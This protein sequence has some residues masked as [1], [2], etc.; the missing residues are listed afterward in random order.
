MSSI[1]AGTTSGTALVSSGDTSGTLLLQTN[2]TTTAVTIGTNQVV[3]LAQPLPVASGGTGATSLSGV[4]VGNLTGGSN[5]T[6][7]YQTASGTTAMLAAGTSGQLLKSNGAS[8]PSW[9]TASASGLTLLSTVTASNSAT[10]DI[11]TTF[12]ST[13]DSYVIVFSNMSPDTDTVTPRVRLKLSGTYQTSGY[14][15]HSAY[16]SNASSSYAAQGGS[17][18]AYIALMGG[19]T[20]DSRSTNPDSTIDMHL[21]INQPSNSVPYK[22]ISWNGSHAGSTFNVLFGSG[23]N[24]TYIGATVLTGVRFYYSSGNVAT[25]TFRLYGYANT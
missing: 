23:Q 19:I 20:Q 5:G 14:N 6:I 8:A 25:G 10:V 9:V 7:P 15:Y 24:D 18:Q 1:S 4:A 22:S 21:R 2:G 13:Y 16:P 12:S 3:T 17:S 11:D